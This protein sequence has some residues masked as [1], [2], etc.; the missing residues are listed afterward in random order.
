M[1][2]HH[3]NKYKSAKY[4]IIANALFVKNIVM[5][6]TYASINTMITIYS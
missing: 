5:N 6:N 2:H 3:K 4:S 1:F